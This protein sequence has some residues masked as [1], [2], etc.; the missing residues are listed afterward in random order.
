MQGNPL[1]R[2]GEWGILTQSHNGGWSMNRPIFLVTLL[3]SMLALAV[4]TPA[5]AEVDPAS[6]AAQELAAESRGDVAAALALYAD[7]AIVQYGGLCAP[8]CV[9]KAAIQKELERRVGA[10]NRWTVVGKYVS[11]NV[12]VIK[13]ELQIGYIEASGVDRVIVWCIYETKGDKIAAVTLAG[14]RTDPQTARL[15]EWFQSQSKPP[16]R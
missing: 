2:R 16:A 3:A 7:D 6:L 8:T 14:Q 12:A 10:K 15:I 9:G 4:S 11:G 1:L 13:T 5:P